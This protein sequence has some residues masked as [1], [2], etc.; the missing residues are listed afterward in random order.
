MLLPLEKKGRKEGSSRLGE[1]QLP[2]TTR[3]NMS[4]TDLQRSTFV[5]LR[6]ERY[7]VPTERDEQTDAQNYYYSGCI[8]LHVY[9]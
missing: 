8:I 6:V 9:Y 5:G 3:P 7:T 2:S 1:S 4:V